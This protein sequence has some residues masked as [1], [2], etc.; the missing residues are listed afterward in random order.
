VKS[1]TTTDHGTVTDIDGNTYNTVQIGNQIWMKEDLRVTKL[2]DGTP[3]PLIPD[4][5]TWKTNT[6]AAYCTYDNNAPEDTYGF[7]YN[8]HTVM[9][10]KLAPT[11]WHVP[12]ET[13]LE[14]LFSSLA[15]NGEN[16]EHNA[17]K[18]KEA[19]ATH[20]LPDYANGTNFSGFTALPGGYRS[21][22]GIYNDKGNSGYW[23]TSTFY[24]GSYKSM[25]M[26]FD[27]YNYSMPINSGLSIRCL[28]DHPAIVTSYLK[29]VRQTTA[30]FG[31]NVSAAG[32]QITRT[33]ICWSN[34]QNSETVTDVDGNIYHTITIGTQ[35]WMVENLRT[36][37]YK[38]GTPIAVISG[39]H[40]TNPGYS[41]Y[42]NSSSNK[43]IYG[44][45]YNWYAV[46][47]GNLAP[48]GWRILTSNDW[49]TLIEYLGG[50]E[51]AGSKLK[52]SGTIHWESP[53]NDAMDWGFTALPG[54][55]R[56]GGSATFRTLKYRGWWWST[57]HQR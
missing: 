6:T 11:G 2:N 56:D 36:T 41:T 28:K 51:D 17:I 26:D 18:L 34:T 39:Y 40:S 31:I 52:E 21:E 44:L 25:I 32:G 20:W 14:M 57:T 15:Y 47:T 4:V 12:T 10:N 9:T 38:D 27:S 35:T 24:E 46:D 42:A 29:D 30:K 1:F 8:Q 23:W 5:E 45:L 43:T 7:L 49:E 48:E 16:Q 37:K 53:N 54:G 13:E 19:E 22:T 3:I 33:G 50:F 55:I